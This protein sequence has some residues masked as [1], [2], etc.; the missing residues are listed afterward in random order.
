MPCR[1]DEEFA[2]GPEEPNPATPSRPRHNAGASDDQSNAED[3]AENDSESDDEDDEDD[4]EKP[5]R[6]RELNVYETVKRWVTGERAEFEPC[7]IQHQQQSR[8]PSVHISS[9]SRILHLMAS[10]TT[11]KTTSP[12]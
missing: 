1:P 3:P 6:F 5:K 2:Q 10:I 7:D 4:Q 8:R 11:S 9:T 12:I